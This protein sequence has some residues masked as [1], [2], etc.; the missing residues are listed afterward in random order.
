MRRKHTWQHRAEAE[1]MVGAQPGEQ[2]AA[3]AA[4]GRQALLD[5][6]DATPF[7]QRV[8]RPGAIQFDEWVALPRALVD[9]ALELRQQRQQRRKLAR[10]LALE[11]GGLGRHVKAVAGQGDLKWDLERRATASQALRQPELR[12]QA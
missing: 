1:W 5:A 6:R 2:P 3:C 10:D 11:L 9:Q 7:E 4:R 12:E 8:R